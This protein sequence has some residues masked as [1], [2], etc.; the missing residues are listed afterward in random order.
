MQELAPSKERRDVQEADEAEYKARQ[1]RQN[2]AAF[3]QA[4]AAAGP[5]GI[6]PAYQAPNQPPYAGVGVAGPYGGGAA[7]VNNVHVGPSAGYPRPTPPRP[8]PQVNNYIH[9]NNMHQ[10]HR[11]PHA[12]LSSY[13]PQT[14]RTGPGPTGMMLVGN[15]PQTTRTPTLPGPPKGVVFGGNSARPGVGGGPFRPTTP[16]GTGYR[17]HGNAPYNR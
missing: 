16:V 15:N 11:P 6:A 3:A 12:G 5:Y 14:P 7:M 10:Y 2:V 17:T 8:Q 9:N 4:S 1:Q 13:R